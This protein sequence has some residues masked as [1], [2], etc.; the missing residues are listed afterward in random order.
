M[1]QVSVE[2]ARIVEPQG[3]RDSGNGAYY[4][5]H[6]LPIVGGN[7]IEFLK[8]AA[9]SNERRRARFCAHPSAD[10]DQHDMLIVSHRDTY[11]TPHRH[12]SKSESFL[13]LEGLA[14]LILFDDHGGVTKVVKLGALDSGRPFFYRMPPGCFHALSIETELLVF[15]E[16][17]KGPFALEDREHAGWAPHPDDS[18][19]GKAYI[20]SIMRTIRP[21][22]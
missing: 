19:G 3:L 10:A 16:S 7:V 5:P 20:D 11:V 22:A 9:R 2:A 15:V 13:V 18:R 21:G 12:L 4:S 6:A 8:E 17:T 1:K 14:S